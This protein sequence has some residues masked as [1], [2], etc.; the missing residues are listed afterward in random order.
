MMKNNNVIIIP[1]RGGSKGIPGKNIKKLNGK[2]LL[3]Y[4]YQSA[5]KSDSLI[6]VF[7]LFS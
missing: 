4:T 5:K 1:A 2:P 6:V 7:G 3:E